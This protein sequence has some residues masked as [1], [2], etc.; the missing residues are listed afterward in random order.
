MNALPACYTE[1]R[2]AKRDVRKV[3]NCWVEQL[4]EYRGIETK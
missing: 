3:K 1:N 2:K 4:K